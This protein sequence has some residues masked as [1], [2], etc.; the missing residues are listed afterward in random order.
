MQGILIRAAAEADFN[1][2]ILLFKEFSVYQKL[3]GRMKNNFN[4]LKEEKDFFHGFV[5]ET[6]DK[7]IIGYATWFFTYYT[8]SGKG[9]YIDDLYIVPEFRG[10]GIGTLLM[11]RITSFAKENKCHKVRWQVSHWNTSAIEFYRK[12]GAEIDDLEKNC[13]LNLD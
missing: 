11:E 3:P 10:K 5:A 9:L 4:Q 12:M 13:D 1:Q 6:S 2:L 8:W 7:K